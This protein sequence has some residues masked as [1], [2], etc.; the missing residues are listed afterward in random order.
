MDTYAV[1]YLRQQMIA[2]Q[3]V[4]SETRTS[5]ENGIFAMQKLCI[6]QEMI[7]RPRQEQ[8]GA[9]HE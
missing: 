2:G 9:I 6:C 4:L 8:I 1:S 3:I 5:A 7:G